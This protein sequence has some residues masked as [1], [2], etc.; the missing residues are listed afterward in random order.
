MRWLSTI[1]L[2][3]SVLFLAVTALASEHYDFRAFYCAGWVARSGGDPYRT[4]PLAGCERTLTY[5]NKAWLTNGPLP[6]PFPPYVI[7]A[8]FEPVS[9]LPYRLAARLWTVLL[10]AALV[11]S[12][13]LLA[14]AASCRPAL[15]AAALCLSAGI[16]S[17]SFGEIVP[18]YLALLCSVIVAAQRRMWIVASLCACATLIE[19]HLGLPVCAALVVFQRRC[20]LPIASGVAFLALLSAGAFGLQRVAEYVHPVLHYHALSEIGSD[21]QF[22]LS[23]VLHWL[24]MTDASAMA[25]GMGSYALAVVAGIVVSGV[26]A[27]RFEDPGFLAAVPAA[28][29]LFGGVFMHVTQMV[30]ALPVALLLLHHRKHARVLLAGA[31]ALLSIPWVWQLNPLVTVIAFCIALAVPW[32]AC[33]TKAFAIAAVPAVICV[34]LFAYSQPPP[35]R[36]A[37]AGPA[38]TSI[39][40]AYAERSWAE[41]NARY[42][43]SGS[44]DAWARRAATWA[45]LL[46]ILG[47]CIAA[48]GKR[49][50]YPSTISMMPPVLAGATGAG[51]A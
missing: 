22:A 41:Q 35:E 51:D 15:P 28:F 42:L 38:H 45:G 36:R 26:L 21:R 46:L 7:A 12:I 40:P 23:T 6:A 37:F 25:A 27:R 10:F 29:A 17:L 44:A 14:K 32:E 34:L 9:L 31:L 16:A 33:R 19:P 4:E 49:R 13:F 8:A 47:S 20:R 39:D 3:A 24:G 50:S 43:S 48:S 1:L 18:L 5:T 2:A 11:V 30:A